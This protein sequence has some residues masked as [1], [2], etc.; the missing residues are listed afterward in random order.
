MAQPILFSSDLA[1]K[2]VLP[3]FY[4]E[5]VNG[6]D[7]SPWMG[8]ADYPIHVKDVEYGT[9]ELVY[10]AMLDAAD[11]DLA[12]IDM[13]QAKGTGQRQVI[14]ADEVRIHQIRQVLGLDG[15][16]ILKLRTPIDLFNALKPQLL[17][18]VQ[19]RYRNDLLDAARYAPS[20]ADGSSPSIHRSLF[21]NVTN[22][23]KDGNWNTKM[24]TALGAC[25]DVDGITV[26][27][28]IQLRERAM[29]G[30]AFTQ[31]STE[32]KIRPSKILMKNAMKE[33]RFVLL[34][35]T[36][37]FGT[38]TKDAKWQQYGPM[39]GVI[40][41]DMQPSII[42]GSRFRGMIDGVLIYEMPELERNTYKGRG[43]GGR[44]ILHSIFMGA[45]AWGVCHAG[46]S[47]FASE[48]DDFG[49]T[50]ELCHIL[51]R[52]LKMLKFESVNNAGT[53]IENGMIHSFTSATT[54]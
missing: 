7:L 47:D 36:R 41:S 8:G 19:Q 26:D 23:K 9:G 39:R 33:E 34:L 50:F 52:G 6:N 45:Q 43:A 5:Y 27:H 42:S 51:Q 37:A 46:I 29:N 25:G 35:T 3:D 31:A 11:P 17:T 28:I 18:A 1:T 38:L 32:K 2:N 10:F 12:A 13:Q 22:A 44:D 16:R 14:H 53:F 40:E 49:N 54:A 24:N 48:Y 21:G 30:G 15:P 20:T 4:S